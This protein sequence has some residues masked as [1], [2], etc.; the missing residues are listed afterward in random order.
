MANNIQDIMADMKTMA[1]QFIEDAFAFV[2]RQRES[3]QRLDV[4]QGL[5]GWRAA[6]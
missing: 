2:D 5:N 6:V 4:L 3:E 1:D